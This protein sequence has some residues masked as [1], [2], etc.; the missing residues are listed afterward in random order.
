MPVAGN[1]APLGGVSPAMKMN[2]GS[3]AGLGGGV[4]R[5]VGG[6]SGAKALNGAKLAPGGTKAA[7][8]GPATMNDKLKALGQQ[9]QQRQNG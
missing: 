2:Q 1:R 7:P 5:G 9:R 6:P 4:A 8:S 3:K